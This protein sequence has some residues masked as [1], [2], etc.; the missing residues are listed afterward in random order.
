MTDRPE[1][2]GDPDDLP[3]SDPGTTGAD[4][5]TTRM[6][7]GEEVP[8]VPLPPATVGATTGASAGVPAGTDAPT[9]PMSAADDAMVAPHVPLA[10]VPP[11]EAPTEQ[12]QP[13]TTAAP[14]G[15][16]VRR[17]SAIPWLLA[18]GVVVLAA[19]VAG[20][21]FAAI[22]QR[23]PAPAG[24]TTSATPPPVE[25]S[26]P[27]SPTPTTRRSSPAPSRSSA[28]A[29]PAPAPAPAPAQP[30]VAPPAPAPAQPTVAPPPEPEPT[31]SGGTAD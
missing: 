13:V 25:T 3:A 27:P 4:A 21:V 18:L 5:P 7:A 11:A 17:R 28:P 20:I 29:A 24:T 9:V 6:P 12:L 10:D 23:A 14:A 8:T 22:G 30:T 15:A 19:V 1:A 2:T 26:A 16:P 31:P